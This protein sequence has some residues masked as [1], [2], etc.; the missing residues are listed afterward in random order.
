VL[1]LM[2]LLPMR[3]L[4]LLPLVVSMTKATADAAQPRAIDA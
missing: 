1:V 3:L 4:P 2:A